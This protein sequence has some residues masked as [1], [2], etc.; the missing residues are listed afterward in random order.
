MNRCGPVDLN[1]SSHRATVPGYARCAVDCRYLRWHATREKI[2]MGRA[3]SPHSSP[4]QMDERAALSEL[5]Q[6]STSGG[7]HGFTA[8]GGT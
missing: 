6:A 2:I 7:Y 8:D 5:E 4:F 1:A 3:V